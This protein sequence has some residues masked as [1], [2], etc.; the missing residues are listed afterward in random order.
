MKEF[1]FYLNKILKL[2]RD[3]KNGGA[4]HKP[5]LLLS[6]ISNIESGLIKT[7]R[8]NI[9]PELVS[10]FSKN[11]SNFVV[12]SH[13]HCVFALPFYHL[14]SSGFWTLEP[15][16]GFELVVESKIAMKTFSNLDTAINCAMLDEELFVLLSDKISRD[17]IKSKIIEKYFPKAKTLKLN[18]GVKAIL[19]METEVLSEPSVD[20]VLKV[21]GLEL[22]LELENF[23]EELFKRGAIFKRNIPKIYNN[24][25]AISRLRVS[26][27][28]NASLIDACHI[29]PISLSL[30][31]TMTNGIS[32]TPTLHR[33]FDRGLISFNNHYEVI[34]STKY[35]ESLESTYSISQFEGTQ[36]LLP[37]ESKYHP[38]LNGIKWHR[39]NVFKP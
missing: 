2:R 3:N 12:G 33:A 14:R 15:K 38:N 35:T 20:Y 30:D 29:K 6:L 39:E 10:S 4:P 13:H 27:T 22:S 26:T 8:I 34:I 11:W 25:C 36:I 9:T 1:D 7:N 21:R 17:L 23:Q 19:K 16:N 31:D 24:T 28:F 18:D 5:I 37:K 32:L